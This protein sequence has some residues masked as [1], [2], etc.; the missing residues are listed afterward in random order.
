MNYDLAY[1]EKMLREYSATAESISK[2]RWKFIEPLN[3]KEVLDYGSGVGWFRAWRPEGVT[4]HSFDVA[5]YP[6]TSSV[7]SDCSNMPVN[8]VYDVV[9]FWDVIEHLPSFKD[10]E[11]TLRRS[12]AVAATIPVTDNV[13]D[14]TDWKH[15]KPGEHLHYFTTK[16]VIALFDAYG[17]EIITMAYC[18]C[19]PREDVCSF[20]FRRKGALDE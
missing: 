10:I 20:L 11:H 5:P 17:F 19:P 9:C 16:Q 3:P 12:K 14:L 13:S 15:F 2:A 8:G 6:Q 7:R 1:Y 18:E 4:V